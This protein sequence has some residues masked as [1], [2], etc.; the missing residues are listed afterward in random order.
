MFLVP[1]LFRFFI[2]LGFRTKTKK[3]LKSLAVFLFLVLRFSF[4]QSFFQFLFCFDLKKT[5]NPKKR[6]KKKF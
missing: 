2:L 6:K 4:C 3:I 5:K 1:V